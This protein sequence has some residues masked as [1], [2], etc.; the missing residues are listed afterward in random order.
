MTDGGT[1]IMRNGPASSRHAARRVLERTRD[2]H[3]PS[4]APF[5]IDIE[6]HE[7]PAGNGDALGTLRHTTRLDL[8]RSTTRASFWSG[9]AAGLATL[10]VGVAIAFTAFTSES[11]PAYGT[12]PRRPRVVAHVASSLGIE[13]PEASDAKV[14][15]KA[16]KK[17]AHRVRRPAPAAAEAAARPTEEAAPEAPLD[18]PAPAPGPEPTENE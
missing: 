11:A 12:E 6:D 16:L 5:A 18:I 1:L 7:V 14:D 15:V 8:G 9:V 2:H 10:G 3:S 13:S 17:K 4:I